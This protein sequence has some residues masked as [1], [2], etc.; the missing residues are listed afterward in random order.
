M[1]DSDRK[2]MGAF[3]IAFIAL[4]MALVPKVSEIW[5]YENGAP[6]VT[7]REN[8]GENIGTRP[9]LHFIP[10]ENIWFEIEDNEADNEIRIKIFGKGGGGDGIS[11]PYVIG[12]IAGENIKIENTGPNGSGY[13]T[14]HIHENLTLKFENIDNKLKLIDDNI[15]LLWDNINLL[16]DNAALQAQILENHENRISTL[17]SGAGAGAAYNPWGRKFF[18]ASYGGTLLTAV[19]GSGYVSS[20]Y[21][22]RLRL[23]T[24]TTANSYIITYFYPGWRLDKNTEIGTDIMTPSTAP[25][26]NWQTCI[27][28]YG[29]SYVYSYTASAYTAGFWIVKDA[30]YN[31]RLLCVTQNGAY[32]QTITDL[33]DCPF[34]QTPMSLRIEIK[35]DVIRYY[36]DGILVAEH[37]TPSLL[38]SSYLALVFHS[39]ANTTTD[40]ILGCTHSSLRI[41][42]DY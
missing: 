6:G 26:V 16:L 20:N 37:S 3:A 22:S 13:V 32:G 9:R 31:N 39:V 18:S 10:T 35:Q 12:I 7:V 19:S 5:I 11:G 25:T 30:V 24:G 15:G 17:E 41:Y 40:D 28:G 21:V 38:W 4:A 1:N 36:K 29:R 33:G 27:L 23:G 34:L 42:Q 8:F 2:T 14:V